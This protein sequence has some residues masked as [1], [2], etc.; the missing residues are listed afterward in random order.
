[1]FAAVVRLARAAALEPVV[2]EVRVGV[3]MMEVV[4]PISVVS[5]AVVSVAV[6]SAA[7]ILVPA[8]LLERKLLAHADIQFGHAFLLG[9]GE[10]IGQQRSYVN[11]YII[12]KS[13]IRI[14]VL[15]Q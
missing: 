5:V 9:D 7:A 10:D 8:L 13:Y 14:S 2:P 3:V 15:E 4:V 6:A 11:Q 1:L 12:N